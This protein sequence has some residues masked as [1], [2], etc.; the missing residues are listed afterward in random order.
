MR[1]S[2]LI[3]EGFK[4][5]D[6]PVEESGDKTDYYYY[7]YNLGLHDILVSTSST[8]AS[9]KNWE[10]YLNENYFAIRDI[11]DVQTLIA[12]FNKWSKK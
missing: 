8:E 4:R 1:E 2:E 10:V 3:E 11:E 6:V 7:K 5:V 9:Q 12:L